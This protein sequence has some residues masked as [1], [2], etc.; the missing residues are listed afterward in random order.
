MNKIAL[1]LWCMLLLGFVVSGCTHFPDHDAISEAGNQ[2]VRTQFKEMIASQKDCQ[3]C[4]DGAVKSRFENFFYNGSVSGYLQAMSPSFLKFMALSPLGQPVIVL[5]SDGETFHY[6]DVVKQTEYSGSVRGETFQ[7]YAPA[8]FSPEFT[9]YWLTGKLRPG[10]VNL[11]LTSREANGSRYWLELYYDD[12]RKSMVLFDA[13]HLHIYQH[14][15]Y[16]ADQEV[17]L[18]ILYDDYDQGECGVPHSVMV[19]SLTLN[20]ALHL[21]FNA[22]VDKVVLSRSDFSY[23]V[24]DGFQQEVVK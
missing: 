11:V 21:K 2:A 9:F 16:N 14:I 13:A 19:T 22:L 18:E 6:V 20:T 12:G 3:C 23:M 7:K 24:P 1:P 15:V 17:I 5:T 8:G 4:F 10:N